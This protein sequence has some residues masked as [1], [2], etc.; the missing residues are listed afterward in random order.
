MRIEGTPGQTLPSA[1]LWLTRAEAVELR[2]ALDQMLA[3]GDST[4]HAHI[5]SAD[6]QTEVTVTLDLQASPAA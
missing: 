1:Y 4:W 5:A 6:Y 3:D 2:D